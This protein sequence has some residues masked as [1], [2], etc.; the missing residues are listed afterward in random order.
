MDLVVDVVDVV[1]AVVVDVVEDVV[2]VNHA[3]LVDVG[4][5]VIRPSVRP[6]ARPSAPSVHPPSVRPPPV[7]PSA[8]PPASPADRA[9]A[10]TITIKINH[11][12]MERKTTRLDIWSWV[13]LHGVPCREI[14]EFFRI[15]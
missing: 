1:G 6:P 9:L 7:R 5:V 8:R 13:V 14:L 10:L 4:V 15:S 11:S 2:D 12:S 3:Y